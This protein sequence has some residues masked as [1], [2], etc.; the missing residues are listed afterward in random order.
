MPRH[1]PSLRPTDPRPRPGCRGKPR[2]SQR[3]TGAGAQQL[4]KPRVPG[5]HRGRRAADRQVLP[6][7][8]LERRGD[9]RGARL[10]RRAG[11]MRGAGGGAAVARRRKPVRILRLPLR[12]VPAARRARARAGQSRPALPPRPVARPPARGRRHA[13]V[14]APRGARCGQLRP[15]LAG[16]PAGRQFHPQEPAAGL[17]V[18]RPRPAETPRRPVRRGALPADPPARRLPS[19]QP[20]VPRRGLPHGRSRRLPHGPS[21]PGPVDDARWRA[22]RTPGADCRTGRRLQRV[23]RLRAAPATAAR[24]PAQPPPDALQRLARAALGRPGV[25][26]SFPWFGSER[27]W[28]EQVLV[29]REQLAAL[30]E[31]PLRLF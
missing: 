20:A 2:L 8:P 13:A 11:G 16:H 29:L 3:R 23:P 21:P 14:R 6:T 28:G 4:R 31:E 24:R 25:P 5:R 7:G 26:P 12:P 10:L 15:R 30:D 9:P 22:P 17:R 1:V 18:G 27:Y 19:G